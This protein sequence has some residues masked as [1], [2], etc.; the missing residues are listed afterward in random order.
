MARF[1]KSLRRRGFAFGLAIV[2]IGAGSVAYAMSSSGTATR[3]VMATAARGDVAQLL[4][5]TGSVQ[6]ANQKSVS[7]GVSGSVTAVSVALGDTVTAGQQLAQIDPAPLQSA[8]LDAQATLAQAKAAVESDQSGASSSGSSG[9]S[10]ASANSSA[11]TTSTV[12]ALTATA[13]EV[14]QSTSALAMTTANN[15]TASNTTAGSSTGRGQGRGTPTAADIAALKTQIESAQAQLSTATSEAKSASVQAQIDCGTAPSP[16]SIATPSPTPSPTGTGSGASGSSCLTDVQTIATALS[17]SAH[18]QAQLT[19][20]TRQLT[21]DSAVLAKAVSSSSVKGSSGGAQPGST[22]SNKTRTTS[23]AS[24]SGTTARSTTTGSS[25]NASSSGQTGSSGQS[26]ASRLITDNA[27]VQSA[28]V[29]LTDAQNNLAGSVLRAPFAGT[30]AAIGLTVGSTASRT[31]TVTIAGA[32]GAK[33]TVNVP[34]ANIRSV[35]VGQV[36]EVTPSGGTTASAGTVQSIGLLPASSTTGTVSYPVV[37]LVPRA[38]SALAT[39]SRAQVNIV[40]ATAKAVLTV[41][42]SALTS[43]GAGAGAASVTVLTNGVA[44]RRSIKTGAVGQFSTQVTSGLSAGDQ[45]VLAD[46]TQ[47]LPT[48]SATTTTG[49]FAGGTGFGGGTGGA[50]FGGGTG[51]AGFGG[52]T[53]ATRPGG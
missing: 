45:I 10:A 30:V 27:A 34:L 16:S 28:Q 31:N 38:V 11:A 36:A 24:S 39:G 23:G 21:T 7:F 37:I 20:L 41:P 22:T 15:M 18:S 25:A 14:T 50:G 8:V 35:R 3:Y 13:T 42:N 19:S 4:G 51:G 53:G 43:A 40:I 32:G 52:G 44:T 1:G 46:R 17:A 5:L 47:S 9:A 26:A 6:Q 29:A 49:R 48:N 33:V 12:S 2:L